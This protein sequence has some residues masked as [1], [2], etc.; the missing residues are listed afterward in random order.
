MIVICRWLLEHCRVKGLGYEIWRE[1]WFVLRYGFGLDL[2]CGIE[3]ERMGLGVLRLNWKGCREGWIEED[4]HTIRWRKFLTLLRA[5]GEWHC[6]SLG[7]YSSP[8]L[9]TFVFFFLFLF[10]LFL[11]FHRFLFRFRLFIRITS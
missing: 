10:H 7:L 2:K 6:W 9:F 5:I 1:I 8:F 11:F 4:I 3:A